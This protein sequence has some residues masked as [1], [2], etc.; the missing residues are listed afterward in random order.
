MKRILTAV[1]LALLFLINIAKSQDSGPMDVTVSPDDFNTESN[2]AA[3]NSSDSGQVWYTVFS[4]SNTYVYAI[5]NKRDICLTQVTQVGEN[6]EHK[7]LVAFK[8]GTSDCNVRTA[9]IGKTS[10]G[11][12]VILDKGYGGVSVFFEATD[13]LKTK[14]SN[15]GDISIETPEIS[16]T[17]NSDSDSSDQEP[18]TSNNTQN[19]Y[20]IIEASF[21]KGKYT[22]VT[23]RDSERK[24][25]PLYIVCVTNLLY[26]PDGNVAGCRIPYMIVATNDDEKH[27]MRAGFKGQQCVGEKW[28]GFFNDTEC[29]KKMKEQGYVIAIDE[30][31]Y[32]SVHISA[33]EDISHVFTRDKNISPSNSFYTCKIDGNFEFD[34]SG[35]LVNCD[36][37]YQVQLN[38]YK[39]SRGFFKT[40]TLRAGSMFEEDILYM[41]PR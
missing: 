41:I 4:A 1:I 14:A 18:S 29:A 19:V 21:T 24:A 37:Y 3:N 6:S 7:Y 11:N 33:L 28:D 23:E 25:L 26:T 32:F 5:F 16:P 34:N 30:N 35:N 22:I 2:S 9:K 13:E 40:R 27:S 15:G 12:P 31:S 20:K 38:K 39:D 17:D 8:Y 36:H 10:N